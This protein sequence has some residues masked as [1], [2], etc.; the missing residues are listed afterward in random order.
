MAFTDL[1]KDDLVRAANF[2][3][4]DIDPSETKAGIAMALLDAG[5]TPEQWEA[6]ADRWVN[7]DPD[8]LPNGA[9]TTADLNGSD[10]EEQTVTE[11]PAE[12]E[13]AMVLVRFIGHNASYQTRYGKFSKGRPFALLTRDQ[14]E[15]LDRLKF[16]EA[17]KAEA[18]EF[19]G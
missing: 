18:A 3:K 7:G 17:T 12:E 5:H 14:F 2:Y 16:R 15:S 4:V 1:K 13:D 19:Y 10:E 11:E 8:D 9:I 6:D